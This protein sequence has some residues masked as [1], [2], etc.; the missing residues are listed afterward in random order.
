[1]SPAA[2]LNASQTAGPTW[3]SCTQQQQQRELGEGGYYGLVWSDALCDRSQPGAAV[4]KCQPGTVTTVAA[5]QQQQQGS[6]N[7]VGL[8]ASYTN[9]QQ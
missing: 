7:L 9:Q 8:W 4:I 6:G 3:T 2:S 5:Q 1:V